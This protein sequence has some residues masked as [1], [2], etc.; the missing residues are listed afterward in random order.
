MYVFSFC[1]FFQVECK[2]SGK[3]EVEVTIEEHFR[4]EGRRQTK[5]HGSKLS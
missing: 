1:I 5:G 3:K 4:G 2:N